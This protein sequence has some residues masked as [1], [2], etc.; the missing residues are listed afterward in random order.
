MGHGRTER[1]LAPIEGNA[2]R[3]RVKVGGP[4]SLKVLIADDAAEVAEVI[5]FG[6]RMTWPGS[7]V[8][9]VSSGQA[10]LDAFAAAA[11]DLVVLDTAISPPGGFDVCRH[12]RD[13]SNVPIL[14]LSV[15]DATIDKVRAFDHGADDY[16]TKPFDDM[17]LLARLRALV[18][19]AGLPTSAAGSAFATDDLTIDYTM[20][21]VRLRGEVVRFTSTEFRLLEA[22]ARNAGTTLPHRVLLERVWGDEWIA[23]SSY[24]KVYVRRL[25]QKLGD[26]AAQPR[27]ILTERGLG[28][29]FLAAP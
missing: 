29:R 8:T 3:T 11:A 7:E 26:D 19:R 23:D 5:A 17:E 15:Q 14:M 2:R 13:T 1:V 27:Y 24:L 12:I 9:T 20:R 4:M 25:R 10:A 21:E 16:L 22:L 18:R 6:A 28:Y